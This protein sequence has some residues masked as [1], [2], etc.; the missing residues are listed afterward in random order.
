M[1]LQ[2][3]TFIEAVIYFYSNIVLSDNVNGVACSDEPTENYSLNLQRPSAL[4][5][6]IVSF[7]S[8]FSCQ[9]TTT[10]LVHSHRSHSVLF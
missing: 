5:S 7:S 2:F 10:V 3:N 4:R 8:L 6:F 1:N 9:A